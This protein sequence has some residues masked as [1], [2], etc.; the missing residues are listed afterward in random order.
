MA[1]IRKRRLPDWVSHSRG[2]SRLV[3]TS[4]SFSS[5][6]LTRGD[7]DFMTL[8]AACSRGKIIDLFCVFGAL[9]PQWV[10]P[11]GK[12]LQREEVEIISDSRACL[13]AAACVRQVFLH[14]TTVRLMAGASPT[15]THQLLEHNLR[16]RTHS[17]YTAGENTLHPCRAQR[18]L[19]AVSA[20]SPPPAV[21]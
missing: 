3:L 19:A 20:T 11:S 16:R 17:A 21:A 6:A 12:W 7:A 13:R 15:R 2:V 5:V 9:K 18:L 14:E 10:K 1:A 8:V 4:L